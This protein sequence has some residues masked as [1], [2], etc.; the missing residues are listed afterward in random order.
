MYYLCKTV[1]EANLV[2]LSAISVLPQAYHNY[3]F[4]R[5]MMQ[6]V[7]KKSPESAAQ[8]L[9]L[10]F[11]RGVNPGPLHFNLAIGALLRSGTETNSEKA[12]LMG[13]R[14][15]EEALRTTTPQ[16][17][18]FQ[19][20]Y[21]TQLTPIL[22]R[23]RDFDGPLVPFF[24]SRPIPMA[25]M[26]TFAHLIRHHTAKWDWDHIE[27]LQNALIQLERPPNAPLLN[28][29]LMV[30]LRRSKYEEVWNRFEAMTHPPPGI[31]PV[32]PNGGTY[33]ALWKTL[34]LALGDN[35]T[36]DFESLPPPRQL[37]AKMT[38]WWVTVKRSP[39]A[40]NYLLGLSGP[41]REITGLIQ[42]C[43]SY[44]KD[45]AGALVALHALKARFGIFPTNQTAEILVK[46]MAWIDLRRESSSVRGSYYY[47]GVHTQNISKMSQVYQA[48]IRRRLEGLKKSE[49][50]ST[51]MT[52]Q[53]RGELDLN[54]LS[55]FVR[56]VMVRQHGP[57]EVEEMINQAK[58]EMGVPDISTGDLDSFAVT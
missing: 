24:L 16:N 42:H 49:I 50:D 13:W 14:M 8:I 26:T 32:L 22:C 43:F 9:E 41:S 48:L 51:N 23:N 53:E 44:T 18:Q 34:R 54:L 21:S 27:Y 36:W 58:E 55:E 6:A 28:A 12:A 15:V 29:L 45:V 33:R 37:M 7:T 1:D 25:D 19:Q 10:M 5:W 56:V 17:T 39:Q 57:A 11:E 52:R 4:R 46:Q 2:A 31:K 47:T 30:D 35:H 38:E 20:S 40:K 3:I